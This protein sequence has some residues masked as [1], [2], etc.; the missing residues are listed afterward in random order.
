MVRVRVWVWV[1]VGVG[2]GVRVRVRVRVRVSANP[3][4]NPSQGVR[5]KMWSPSHHLDFPIGFRKTVAP[6]TSPNPNPNPDPNPDPNPNPTP[7][8]SH[9]EDDPAVM[10]GIPS[11]LKMAI[12]DRVRGKG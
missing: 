3:N 2:V 6:R 5:W 8:R 12:R 10:D 1:R 7:K 9:F 4:P 11:N